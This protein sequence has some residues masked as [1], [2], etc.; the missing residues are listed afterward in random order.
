MAKSS[1]IRGS[2]GDRNLAADH[3]R[4]KHKSAGEPQKERTI[5]RGLGRRS[6]SSIQ[7]KG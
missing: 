3:G 5:P 7:R 6:G 4:K 2:K 1:E